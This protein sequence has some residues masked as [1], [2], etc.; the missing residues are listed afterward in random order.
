WGRRRLSRGRR[1]GRLRRSRGER[2]G[3]RTKL[4]TDGPCAGDQAGDDRF[5][6]RPVRQPGSQARVYDRRPEAAEV[7]GYWVRGNRRALGW[8]SAGDRREGFAGE[9]IEP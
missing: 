8:G 9:Q 3:S 5:R 4:R 2:R 1:G 7:E 6:G